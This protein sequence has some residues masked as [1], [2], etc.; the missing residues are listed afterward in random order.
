MDVLFEEFDFIHGLLREKAQ[1]IRREVLQV[2]EAPLNV[3]DVAVDGLG[4]D[5]LGRKKA[6]LQVEDGEVG[7]SP[8]MAQYCC[9]VDVEEG[10]GELILSARRRFRRSLLLWK[11]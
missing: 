11:N 5:A 8:G 10:L 4:Q 6:I 2:R 7:S 3:I 1:N 9:R